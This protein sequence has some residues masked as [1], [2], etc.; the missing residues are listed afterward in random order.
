MTFFI[1]TEMSGDWTNIVHQSLFIGDN[2]NSRNHIVELYHTVSNEM[3][4]LIHKESKHIFY[5]L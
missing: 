2:K 5:F 4:V 3:L 1:C